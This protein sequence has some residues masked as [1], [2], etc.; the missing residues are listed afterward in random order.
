MCVGFFFFVFVF[1]SFVCVVFLGFFLTELGE[2]QIFFRS[3]PNLHN[4]ASFLRDH[5]FSIANVL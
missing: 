1:W 2:W 5:I 4:E 3:D